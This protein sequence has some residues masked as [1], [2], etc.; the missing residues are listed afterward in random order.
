MQIKY[1]IKYDE[2]YDRMERLFYLKRGTEKNK[3]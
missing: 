2:L 3:L 1:N